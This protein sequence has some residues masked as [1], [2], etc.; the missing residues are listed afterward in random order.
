MQ[1]G[2]LR[3][4]KLLVLER[5]DKQTNHPQYI[6]YNCKVQCLYI[7]SLLTGWLKRGPTDLRNFDP[8]I[9]CV[10]ATITEL[11]TSPDRQFHIDGFDY[12]TGNGQSASGGG[13]GMNG[14][15]GGESEGPNGV[16]RGGGKEDS[17]TTTKPQR[18]DDT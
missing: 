7:F 13:G 8:I 15:P 2:K 14:T 9:T 1:I 3:W 5:K 16:A 11:P 18:D 12:T 4:P 6:D 17:G 10:P